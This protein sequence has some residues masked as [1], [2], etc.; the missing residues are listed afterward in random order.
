MA[1]PRQWAV[2]EVKY[3]L[4]WKVNGTDRFD[5]GFGKTHASLAQIRKKQCT[6]WVT[7]GA[8]SCPAEILKVLPSP[9]CE[10]C[11]EYLLPNTSYDA[12][13]GHWRECG[14]PSWKERALYAESKLEEYV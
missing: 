11:G 3:T 6:I 12:G 5:V 4:P 14:C 10:R 2:V 9:K 7:G 8:G 13:T 1:K